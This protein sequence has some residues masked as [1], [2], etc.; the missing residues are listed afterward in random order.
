MKFRRCRS[1]EEKRKL[2]EHIGEWDP[3]KTAL[4]TPRMNRDVFRSAT[5]PPFVAAEDASFMRDDDHV[6]GVYHNGEA[7]AYPTFVA[8][9]YHQINDTFG[10]EPVVLNA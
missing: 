7:K 2:I 3:E 1:D 5:N 10:D 9:L 6:W 4:L 8:D